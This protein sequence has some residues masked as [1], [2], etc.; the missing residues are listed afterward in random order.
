VLGDQ[1]VEQVVVA[2]VVACDYLAPERE[3]CID[4]VGDLHVVRSP[5]PRHY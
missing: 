1:L 3:V 2:R 4:V 5:R